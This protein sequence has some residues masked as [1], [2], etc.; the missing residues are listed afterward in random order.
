MKKLCLSL[1]LSSAVLVS[2][3]QKP[4]VLSSA[5]MWQDM[6]SVLA[7]D[8]VESQSIVP[9]GGDPHMYEPTPA[10]AQKILKANLILINGLTFEGWIND[11]IKNSGTTAGQVTITEGI[12]VLTNPLHQNSFD[13][14][15]WMSAANGKIYCT[16]IYAALK[17]LLPGD[18]AVLTSNYWKYMALLD[19]TDKL[20]YSKIQS[21]MPE[22]RVLITSHDAFQ[23]YGRRYGIALHSVMGT[24]TDADVQTSVMRELTDLIRSRRIPAIFVESTIN[25]K[26]LYQLAKDTHTRI[27]GKLF[28]DSLGDSESPASTYVDMLLHNTETIY[29]ALTADAAVIQ[30]EKNNMKYLLL[31]GGTLLMFIFFSILILK[32]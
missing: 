20:I 23:Y 22:N 16:N 27:G 5:S 12:E 26:L 13:P 6:V 25:P 28:A 21:I 32:K 11:L 10:D 18:T 19:S 24:S 30:A 29:T 31:S 8:L 14:H 4:V 7:G 17:N 3:G 2:F 1:M 9:I 15:A